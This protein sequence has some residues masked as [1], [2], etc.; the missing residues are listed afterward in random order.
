MSLK[1][2][3]ASGTKLWLDS[4]DP[5]LVRK[6]HA[7]GATGAT[8][9]P[10][11]IADLIKTGR[12]DSRIEK[13]IDQGLAHRLESLNA[14]VC[15]ANAEKHARTGGVAAFA[16]CNNCRRVDEFA[17]EVVE[18]RLNEWAKAHDFALTQTTIELRGICAECRG[19]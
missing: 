14:F 12:F 18:A 1:S 2:L 5:D 10:I 4:I 11:I 15:C 17:D 7:A 3:I 8:S 13:L 19:N 9:N 16:I 6:N